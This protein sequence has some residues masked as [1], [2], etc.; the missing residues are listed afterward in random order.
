MEISEEVIRPQH[1]DHPDDE[2]F[3][4][5]VI[6]I[7]ERWKES[8]LSGDEWRFNYM[9]Q[10]WRKGEIIVTR[11]VGSDLNRAIA[12]LR[13]YLDTFP[14]DGDV[15][16]REAFERTKSKCDQPGCINEATIF[17]ECNKLYTKQ[18]QEIVKQAYQ[19]F[20]RQFCEMHRERGDCALDDADHNYTPIADPR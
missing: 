17:F 18:G 4:Q 8:E 9:V 19:R 5:V 16:D 7:V 14:A 12:G 10:G 2:R 20:Y 15:F 3:D 11:S 13:G 6:S 1:L